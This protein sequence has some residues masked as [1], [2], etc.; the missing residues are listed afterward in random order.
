MHTPFSQQTL[1]TT[2]SPFRI[3]D[4][5]RRFLLFARCFCV[6]RITITRIISATTTIEHTTA[7]VTTF[8]TSPPFI[9]MDH[10]PRML[11]S[12]MHFFSLLHP[13]GG[14]GSLPSTRYLLFRILLSSMI[15]SFFFPTSFFTYLN[16]SA[17]PLQPYFLEWTDATSLTSNPHTDH[18]MPCR[19]Q[20]QA[21][22]QQSHSKS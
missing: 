14:I 17:I 11:Y 8:I 21:A 6:K 16:G 2:T 19:K 10:S 13:S 5:S 20:N 4:P 18:R 12:Q 1:H 9:P 22:Q 3:N 7:N 15:A